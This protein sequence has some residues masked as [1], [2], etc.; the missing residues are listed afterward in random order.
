M[1]GNVAK[2]FAVGKAQK[3][4]IKCWVEVKDQKG[5]DKGNAEEIAVF[6]IT[7]AVTAILRNLTVMIF[8]K[9]LCVP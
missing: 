2:T 3:D 7:E 9:W 1:E 6:G 4:G 5:K 8:P